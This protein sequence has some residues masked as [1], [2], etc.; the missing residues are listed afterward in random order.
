LGSGSRHAIAVF[1]AHSAQSS[2]SVLF[3]ELKPTD[4]L[5]PGPTPQRHVTSSGRG[6]SLHRALALR[7]LGAVVELRELTADR[8]QRGIFVPDR[9]PALGEEL[10]R[11]HEIGVAARLAERRGPRGLEQALLDRP[12][13]EVR[14]LSFTAVISPAFE[15][16]QWM[17]TLLAEP[18]ALAD[19]S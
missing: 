5:P 4:C 8:A 9:G 15:M 2:S 1:S 6:S 11:H 19:L 13:A 16:S 17:A 18:P 3:A 14:S 7:R 12:R 10:Q